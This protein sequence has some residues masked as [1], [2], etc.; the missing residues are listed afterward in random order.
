[1]SSIMKCWLILHIQSE[2][3]TVAP[4]I[5]DLF[6]DMESKHNW[7][8]DIPNL[9]YFSQ[10]FM[11]RARLYIHRWDRNCAMA[12]PNV[13]KLWSWAVQIVAKLIITRSFFYLKYSHRGHGVECPLWVLILISTLPLSLSCCRW[14]HAAID[15]V[16]STLRPRQNGRHFPDDIVKWIFLNEN[17][18]ISINVSL[19]KFVPKGPINNIPT[20]V[21]IMALRRLGDKPLS[22]PM[23]V[24]LPTH[25]WVNRPQWVKGFDCTL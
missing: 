21:Q 4:I 8:Y 1:M 17:V 23:K 14:Y 13:S 15:H 16:I 9:Y 12:L 2:T 18:W 24:R 22:E 3:S 10:I 20:L 6:A 11:N 19:L 25:I 5:E 7:E